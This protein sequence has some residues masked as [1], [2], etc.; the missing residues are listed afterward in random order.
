MDK[1]VRRV[2]HLKMQFEPSRYPQD[3]DFRVRGSIGMM[4]REIEQQF[5]VNLISVVGPDSPAS[6]PIIRGIFEHSSSPIR[7]D[8]LTALKAIEDQKPSPE[9]EAAKAAQL[10]LPVKEVEKIEAEIAKLLAE[11]DKTDSQA[12]QIDGEIE[13]APLEQSLDQVKLMNEL[14]ET[15]NVARG[16]DIQEDKN[17]LTAEGL[18]IQEKAVDKNASK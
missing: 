1:I 3:Y 17:K 7:G 8:V 4:A 12:E 6:M 10:A 13:A 5:M 14:E 11:A 15:D 18:R 16:L 9:E 2:L